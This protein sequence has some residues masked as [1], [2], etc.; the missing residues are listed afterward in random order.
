MS[1][2]LDKDTRSSSDPTSWG[3]H[4]FS[5]ASHGLDNTKSTGSISL[6]TKGMWGNALHADG[7]FMN[8]A[9]ACK[10]QKTLAKLYA[11]TTEIRSQAS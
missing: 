10:T 1:F 9:C 11:I 6:M 8:I 7:S 5:V 4:C 2:R 3:R